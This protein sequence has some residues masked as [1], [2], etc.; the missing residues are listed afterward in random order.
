M[1][2]SFGNVEDVS[3]FLHHVD[4]AYTTL[5]THNC[6]VFPSITRKIGR[7][8]PRSNYACNTLAIVSVRILCVPHDRLSTTAIYLNLTDTHVIEEYA[9]KW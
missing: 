4:Y 3:S 7:G 8:D 6:K 1:S 2:T 5:Y 9:Q